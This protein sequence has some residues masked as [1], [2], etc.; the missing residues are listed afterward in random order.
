MARLGR[1]WERKARRRRGPDHPATRHVLDYICERF[2]AELATCGSVLDVGCGAGNLI[3]HL[4]AGCSGQIFGIDS[5]RAMAQRA[6]AAGANVVVGEAS[7]LPFPDC[8]FDVVLCCGRLHHVHDI[9][10]TVQEMKRVTRRA[11]L[12]CEPNLYSPLQW[13]SSLRPHEWRAFACTPGRLMAAFRRE[14]G[15]IDVSF[16]GIVGENITPAWIVPLLKTL[17]PIADH[18]APRLTTLGIYLVGRKGR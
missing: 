6:R 9:E 18:F 13:L 15:D 1:T 7:D 3:F 2:R 8:S 5:S 12:A 17:E 10:R 11:V 16:G 4:S 14:F